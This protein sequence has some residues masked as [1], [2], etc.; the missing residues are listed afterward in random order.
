MTPQVAAHVERDTHRRAAYVALPDVHRV[1]AA[2]MRK[3][4]SETRRGSRMGA[5]V[6]VCGHDASYQ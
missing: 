2:N 6:G 5:G 4:A 3:A 1:D